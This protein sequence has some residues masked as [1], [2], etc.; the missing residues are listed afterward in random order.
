MSEKEIPNQEPANQEK[1]AEKGC[2]P[3]YKLSIKDGFQAKLSQEN[4]IRKEKEKTSDSHNF[5]YRL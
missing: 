3:P 2:E 4:K 1:S 5:T